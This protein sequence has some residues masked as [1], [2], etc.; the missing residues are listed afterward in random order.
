LPAIADALVI[1]A[2]VVGASFVEG[3]DAAQS[4]ID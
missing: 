4:D 3:A 1:G 2:P